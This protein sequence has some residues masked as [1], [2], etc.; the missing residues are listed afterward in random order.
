MKSV[1]DMRK[2]ELQHIHGRGFLGKNPARSHPQQP[3]DQ[4]DGL[5]E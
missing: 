2:L 1:P 3:P 4:S 5:Y